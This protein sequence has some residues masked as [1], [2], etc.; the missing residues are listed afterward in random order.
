MIHRLRLLRGVPP[1]VAGLL[2]AACAAVPATPRPPRGY[3]AGP[4]AFLD[5]LAAEQAAVTTLRGQASVRYDGPEGVGS[6]T[7]VIVVALPDRARVEALSPLGTVVLL[8]T[9][10]GD[11]LTVYA[12]ARHEYGTGRATPQLLG[13]LVKIAVPPGPLLRLL[14]GLPPLPIHP[15]DP[16][17]GLRLEGDAIRVDSVDGPFWQRVWSDPDGTGPARGELGEAS[18]LLLRFAFGD[19]RRLDGAMFPS[20]VRLEDATGGTRVAVQYEAVRLNEPVEAELFALPRPDDGATRI[21]N[22]DAGPPR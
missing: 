18:G 22:L 12:P 15:A 10:R 13:R 19:R 21:I 16:R 7:Q 6:A 3:P 5:R 9:I 2:L 17:V 8:L 4:E 1:L 14:V 20:A 11:A